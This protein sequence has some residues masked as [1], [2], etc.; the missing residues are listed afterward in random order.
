MWPISNPTTLSSGPLL[1]E[2]LQDKRSYRQGVCPRAGTTV[3]HGPA[4]CKSRFTTP[5]LRYARRLFHDG[6]NLVL[7]DS[8]SHARFKDSKTNQ[9]RAAC[10]GTNDFPPEY[11]VFNSAAWQS[12]HPEAVRLLQLNAPRTPSRWNLHPGPWDFALNS[13]WPS[14]GKLAVILPHTSRVVRSA[15]SLLGRRRAC[16]TP[17]IRTHL[18]V[19]LEASRSTKHRLGLAM[20]PRAHPPTK[21]T[22]SSSI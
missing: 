18:L 10:S 7:P 1:L 14:R 22:P 19:V 17:A 11:P 8:L 13:E 4:T 20:R 9:G 2:M 5:R 16:R 12:N 15:N 6:E 3:G 21:R